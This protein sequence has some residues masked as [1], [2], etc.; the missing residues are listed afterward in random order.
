MGTTERLAQFII[1]TDYED[2]PPATRHAAKRAMLDTLGV[3]MAGSEEPAG[4]I[5]TSFVSSI[6]GKPRAG[7]VGA[8]FRTSSPNAALANGTMGHALDYDDFCRWANEGHPSVVLLPCVLA[9]GEDFGASGKTLLEAFI[10]G[11]EVIGRLA[12]SG[13]NP[14]AIGFHPTAIFGTM[15]AAAAAAKVI[16]LGVEQ[17][18]MVLGFAA[19]H[20]SGIGRNRGTMTKSCHAGNAARSGVMAALLVKEGFTAA[21]DLIEGRRGFCDTFA[22][23]AEWDDSKITNNLGDSYFISSPGVIVK[24]YPTCAFAHRCIDAILQLSDTYQ[25]SA[26]DVVEVECQTGTMT[27][28][29]LTYN[30]P[31]TYLEG[32][33]SMPFCMAIALLERK[34]GLLQV[35]NEKVN[36]P[37][38]KQLMKQVRLCPGGEPVAAS[39]VVK[40]RLRDGKEYSLG[41]D[42][43]RGHPELPL[44]DEELISKYRD[45]AAIILPQDEVEQV[46]GLMLNLEQLQ[47][48]SELMDIISKNKA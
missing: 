41:I 25:I 37:K 17:T 16:G 7:V 27:G 1:E 39:D 11:F 26:D 43:A 20:A 28:D 23:G 22:G 30:D 5:I 45:C 44:T 3:M 8:G 19:S 36:D 10:L 12:A 6:G 13:I 14:R 29:I 46:L 35:T 34:V 31:V 21:A 42:K 32:K 38:T 24:K 18:R 15:G 9:L 33:F 2:M 4:K 48:T 47:Q 40:V